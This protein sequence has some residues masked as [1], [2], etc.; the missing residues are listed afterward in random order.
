MLEVS[1]H[2]SASQLLLR[3]GDGRFIPANTP[4]AEA[5]TT[6]TKIVGAAVTLNH[7]ASDPILDKPMV[8]VTINNPFRKLLAWIQEIKNKQTTTFEFKIKIP[9][10]ALPIFFVV[11]GSAFMFFFNLGRD[12][13][14][15]SDPITPV[16]VISPTSTIQRTTTKIGILMASH[17][18]STPSSSISASV[19][20]ISNYYLISSNDELTV[21]NPKSTI[22]LEGLINKKVI[23][24]GVYHEDTQTIDI[25]KNSNIESVL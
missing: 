13:E 6:S 5:V 11:L 3:V 4:P 7:I 2:L 19:R 18:A 17:T 15:K 21:L 20:D 23:I 12:A 1:V 10:I 9:L 25:N 22:K 14:K 16:I 8:S 24:T